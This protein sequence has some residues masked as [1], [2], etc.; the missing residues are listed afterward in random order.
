MA[1]EVLSGKE[2]TIL[3]VSFAMDH[4][5]LQ[6]LELILVPIDGQSKEPLATIHPDR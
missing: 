5:S 6:G 2:P 4:T 1:S 3:P